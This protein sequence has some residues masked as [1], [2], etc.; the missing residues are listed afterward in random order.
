MTGN[1]WEIAAVLKV[2]PFSHKSLAK[3]FYAFIR[4]VSQRK[5]SDSRYCLFYIK[6]L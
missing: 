4:I 6:S 1:E 2:L 3:Y 5:P